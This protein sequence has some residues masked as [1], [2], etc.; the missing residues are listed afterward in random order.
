MDSPE[1]ISRLRLSRR[2]LPLAAVVADDLSGA[3]RHWAL[4]LW[5]A[6]SA[7]TAGYWLFNTPVQSENVQTSVSAY[8]SPFIAHQPIAPLASAHRTASDLVARAIHLHLIVLATLVIVLSAG[9]IASESEYLAGS[10]LCR[11][12]SRWQYYFGKCI[13]RMAIVVAA[14]LALSIPVIAIAALRFENDLTWAGVKAAL[15]TGSVVLAMVAACGV[16]G[17]AWFRN[18]MLA[19]AVVWTALYGAGIVVDVMQIEW[20]SPTQFVDCLTDWVSQTEPAVHA[21]RVVTAL[22]LA[23]VA[24]NLVSVVRF[25]Y[26]DA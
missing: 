18:P 19:V 6:L 22:V 5:A 14:F 15:G 13:S 12:I 10:V 16:A 11:G 2:C 1:F 4:L 3:L 23:A 8:P 26:R 17:S 20:L 24:A 9:S 25:T 7:L 21:S